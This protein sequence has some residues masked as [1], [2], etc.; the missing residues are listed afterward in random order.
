MSLDQIGPFSNE[1]Y[2]SAL[3]LSVIAGR[4]E[5]DAI[6]FNQQTLQYHEMLNEIKDVK[7]GI[8]NELQKLT[9][10]PMKKE[11]EKISGRI[12]RLGW[13]LQNVELKNV[14]LAIQTYYPLVYVEFFSAT[15]KYDGRRYGHK[16]EE[17]AGP[18][19]LRRI[20]GGSEI[21]KAEYKGTYYR[22]A[23]KAREA[24]AKSFNEAFKKVD[25]ILCATVPRTP[26]NIGSNIT[27][28]EMYS[29]DALTIPANLA[30]I[31]AISIP[32]TKIDGLPVGLQIMA[33]AFAEARMFQVAEQIE[34]LLKNI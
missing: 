9:P 23:L 12:K 30:G 10:Q 14:D 31:C 2:G 26:H 34:R 29:Y 17:V 18:E 25:I 15:R 20:L 21:S 6:T 13:R 27:P 32:L 1:V 24:I 5:K 22:R 11:I 7:V 8:S 16:I 28:E 3:L 19:V 33:P 4:D